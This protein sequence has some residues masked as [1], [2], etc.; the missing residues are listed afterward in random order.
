MGEL[1]DRINSVLSDPGQM[2]KIT[3][4]AQ[5][6]MGGEPQQGSGD[7]APENTA[8]SAPGQGS[9]GLAAQLGIDPE[10]LGKIKK[11]MDSGGRKKEEKALL[12]AMLPY[13]SEERRSRMDR[14]MKIAKIAG[15]ARLAL[16]D[17]GGDRDA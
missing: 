11:L 1:E 14:A 15:I 2:E 16:G 3:R 12:E 6:L 17:T 10:M 13:L 4:L 7:A 9:G 8:K 5:S